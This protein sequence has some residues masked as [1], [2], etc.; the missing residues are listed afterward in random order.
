M[1]GILSEIADAVNVIDPGVIGIVVGDE[2]VA[3]FRSA[4]IGK[5]RCGSVNPILFAEFLDGGTRV[6]AAGKDPVRGCT[7]VAE[8]G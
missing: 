5:A 6:F 1:S 2:L 3:F 7:K 8:D 4:V